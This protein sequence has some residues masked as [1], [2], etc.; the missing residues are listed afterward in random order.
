MSY[1]NRI[2]DNELQRKLNASGAVL[3]RGAKACG[4][5]ESAKQ[6]AKSILNVDQ[7]EQVT[8]L[9]ETAPQRLLLG[10]TPRLIDEWQEEPKLWN[11]IRHEVDSRRQTMPMCITIAIRVVWR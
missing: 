1:L 4:K 7:D 10:K 9:M 11:F 2:S 3:V 8:A 5:T 6:F